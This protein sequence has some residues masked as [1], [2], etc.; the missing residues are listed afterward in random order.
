MCA[1]RYVHDPWVSGVRICVGVHGNA[2]GGGGGG[3]QK[4]KQLSPELAAVCGRD[5]MPRPQV[6]KQIWAYAKGN[7]LQDGQN[8]NCDKLLKVSGVVLVET[9]GGALQ[10]LLRPSMVGSSLCV[11]SHQNV[12]LVACD[13]TETARP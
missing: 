13:D 5:V 2:E 12:H 10:F 6:V 8:I 4:P 3:L 1:R 11:P 7:K 9:I